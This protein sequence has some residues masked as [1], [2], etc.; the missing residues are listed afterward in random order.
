MR[1]DDLLP[2]PFPGFSDE[3]LAFLSALRDHNERDW[4]KP[5]KA[6]YDDHL[7]A[8]LELLVESASRALAVDGSAFT[9]GRAM[10]IY[11]DVRFSK[12]K[13]PYQTHVSAS[14]DRPGGGEDPVFVYVHVEPGAS[15]VASG[16]YRPPVAYLR[17]VR[18][19]IAERPEAF[20]AMLAE[21]RDAGLEIGSLGH[22]LTNMP[23]GFAA[24]RD[25]PAADY[26]RWETVVAQQSLTDAD[27]QSPGLVD[28]IV[29]TA[30]GARPLVTY[31][32]AA[33]G[34]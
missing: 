2:P 5:R 33:H 1:L 32:D 20:E 15:F 27:V 13:R 29:A 12:D 16:V 34:A 23:R 31:L 8:L 26:L 21:V 24:H 17:P 4:F 25:G 19:R 10:R 30:R 18:T 22:E 14:F 28:Q 6:T 3:G 11:R 9:S 7:K